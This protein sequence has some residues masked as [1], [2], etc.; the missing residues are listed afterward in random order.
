M[1]DAALYD[2]EDTVSKNAYTILVDDQEKAKEI[3]KSMY[4][5]GRKLR[6]EYGRSYY[7]YCPEKIQ[8][9]EV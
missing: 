6:D 8:E 3:A 4:E 9:F 5:D 2:G 7:R 1:I